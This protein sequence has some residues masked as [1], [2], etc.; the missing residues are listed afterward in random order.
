MTW[1]DSPARSGDPEML[2]DQENCLLIP[3]QPWT[4]LPTPLPPTRTERAR[5]HS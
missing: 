2:W 4:P 5:P 1:A 3:K